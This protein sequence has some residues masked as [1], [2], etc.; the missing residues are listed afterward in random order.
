MRKL[1]INSKKQDH[2]HELPYSILR[3]CLNRTAKQ[4]HPNPPKQEFSSFGGNC[5]AQ[6]TPKNQ[7][8]P[9]MEFLLKA[10]HSQA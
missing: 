3:N 6:I 8:R 1:L 5:Q 10:K 4:P 9:S 7:T 2:T